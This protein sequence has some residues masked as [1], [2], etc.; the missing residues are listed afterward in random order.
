[1][2][3]FRKKKVRRIFVFL[4]EQKQLDW[5]HWFGYLGKRI[6]QAC[7]AVGEKL[8]WW[9]GITKPKYY[10]EIREFEQMDEEVRFREKKT[11]NK[12]EMNFSSRN[13]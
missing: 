8:A 3:I 7:D 5:I 2:K 10:D 1:M 12:P 4:D 6:Y 13:R 9:V 11:L